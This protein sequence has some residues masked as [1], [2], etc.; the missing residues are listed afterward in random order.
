MNTQYLS[1]P[2]WQD[3][4]LLATQQDKTI[5]VAESCTGGGIGSALTDIAGSSRVFLGGIIA[6]ANEIKTRLLDVSP[7]TLTSCGAV[8]FETCETMLKGIHK[9]FL[10]SYA[11]ATTGIAG[12]EGGTIE[13]PVGTVF[14]GISTQ[15]ETSLFHCLFHG[16]RADIRRQST[17]FVGWLLVSSLTGNDS[18]FLDPFIVEHRRK[19][20]PEDI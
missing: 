15:K 4:I 2:S 9:L 8:S 12:P 19:I 1:S 16:E 7:E 11:I 20:Y 13:K 6:Y 18:S 14:I 3:I 10:P 5:A 17:S